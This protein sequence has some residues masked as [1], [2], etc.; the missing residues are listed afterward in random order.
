V[1]TD[2]PIGYFGALAS[3]F[4]DA[5]FP[6]LRLAVGPT[7][8]HNA[9]IESALQRVD[10][11]REVGWTAAANFEVDRLRARH[12][13]DDAAL[14]T[15][16][17]ALNERGMTMAGIAIGWELQRRGGH[18]ARLMRILYPFPYRELIEAEARARRVDPFLAAGLIRQESMFNA[19]AVSPAGAVG[20]MQVMPET[21]RAVAGAL[22]IDRFTADMLRNAEVN[23]YLGMAYLA[24]QL[25]TYGDRTD[26]VLAAYNAGPHRVERWRAFPEWRERALFTDR[27]PFAETR[28]YV[29]I[30]DTNARLYR[31]LY[32]TSSAE[33]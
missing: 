19:T 17:E 23:A 28:G 32:G 18:N 11:L 33:R 21:G 4:L 12:A 29:R 20:L 7:A 22:D 2:D 25:R 16:A 8:T 30:V 13:G 14:Y 24:D 31:S 6:A 3:D 15:L 9:A 27:I 10:L 26:A 1:R 5:P